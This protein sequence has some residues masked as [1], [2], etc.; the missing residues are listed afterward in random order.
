VYGRSGGRDRRRLACFFVS[1]I[2]L[3]LLRQADGHQRVRNRIVGIGGQ[4]FP[5][6][7]GRKFVA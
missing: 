2:E 6:L 7:F 3:L 1:L 5:Q 4:G